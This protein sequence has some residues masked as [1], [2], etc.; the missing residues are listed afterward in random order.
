MQN[1]NTLKTSNM[2]KKI[3]ILVLAI[4]LLPLTG[5]AQDIFDKYNDNSDVTYVSIKPKMFQMIAN[6]GINVDDPEAK[7]YLKLWSPITKQFLQ[8]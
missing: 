3:N 5:M 1:F 2:K 8:K 6:M 4:L 7:A